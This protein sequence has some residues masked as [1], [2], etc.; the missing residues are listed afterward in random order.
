MKKRVLLVHYSAPSVLGGVEQVMAAH[1]L[2]LR[3]AGWD[4]AIAAGSGGV[5]RALHGV[6]LVRIAAL[7]SRDRAVLRDFNALA[8]GE[9]RPD[10]R[11]MVARIERALRPHVRRADRVVVHNAFTLHKNPALTEAL[12]QLALELPGRFV[13]WTH[14]LAWTDDQYAAQRHPGEPWD[15]YAR[16]IPG[17][18]YVAVS[19]ERARQL[20][21]LTGLAREEI[22]VVPNGIDLLAL[23]GLSPAGSALAARL[24]LLEA[25]P[26]LLLPARLTRRKRIEAAIDATAAL[27]S[28]GLAAAL[29]VTGTPGPHNPAN[30]AYARELAARAGDGVFLLHALGVRAPYRVVAD[31]FALADALVLPSANEG[32]GIPLLEAGLQRVPIVCSDLPALRAVAGDAA[33]YVS[34]SATGEAIADAIV[35]RLAR[36]GA[37][38]LRRTAKAHAWPRIVRDCV[39]PILEEPV[40]LPAPRATR[41]SRGP[42]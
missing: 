38:G 10:H 17:V 21:E 3:A 32:F 42:S 4:V 26:L 30:A 34:P 22:A 28:R 25:D 31:L 37:A 5:P 14:D 41:S 1:A 7:S 19:D 8:R 13:A 36:D 16:A 20:A 2:G 9:L 24:G 27:R 12:E 29:V 40:N 11:A 15:R 18:R 39:L 23:L 33:T 35:Q 6:R